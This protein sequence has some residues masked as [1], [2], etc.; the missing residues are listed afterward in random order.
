MQYVAGCQNYVSIHKDGHAKRGVAISREASKS[1]IRFG[2]LKLAVVV[3]FSMLLF[4]GFAIV[5]SVASVSTPAPAT[6]TEATVIVSA[7]DTLWGIASTY[8]EEGTDVRKI[9]YAIKKRNSLSGS[10]LQAGQVL[11]IPTVKS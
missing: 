7:G 11:V 9:V 5:Q 4:S 3:L 10:S 8:A 1:G 6:V 2:Y